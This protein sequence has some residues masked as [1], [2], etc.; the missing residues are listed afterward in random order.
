MISRWTCLAW[1]R[2]CRC[3]F[4]VIQQ[5]TYMSRSLI[6]STT[7]ISIVLKTCGTQRGQNCTRSLISKAFTC[8]TLLDGLPGYGSKCPFDFRLRMSGAVVPCDAKSASG[9]ALIVVNALEGVVRS[10]SLSHGLDDVECLSRYRGALSPSRS[11][12]LLLK[13]KMP[14]FATFFDHYE[15]IP[16]APSPSISEE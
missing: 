8:C 5:Q 1:N 15:Q 10:W 14:A 12:D 2:P 9:S 13:Q 7:Q 16:A 11:S 3:C 6:F 4:R